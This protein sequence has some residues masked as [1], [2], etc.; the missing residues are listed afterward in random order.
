MESTRLDVVYLMFK[1]LLNKNVLNRDCVWSLQ[2]LTANHR[3]M[4]ETDILGI[5]LQVAQGVS[6]MHS[7]SPPLAHWSAAPLGQLSHMCWFIDVLATGDTVVNQVAAYRDLKAENVL[8]SLSGSWVV[9]DFGSATTIDEVPQ[10]SRIPALEDTVRRN[11]T[12]AYRAPEV[13]L[14]IN[15]CRRITVKG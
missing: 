2:A 5:F 1:Q 11:T 10:N 13:C 15:E 4:T 7:Q 9:C 6:H 3:H 14:R 12:A 8:Q